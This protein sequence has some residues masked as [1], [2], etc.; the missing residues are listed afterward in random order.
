VD[1]KQEGPQAEDIP[2]DILFEDASILVLNKPA[3]LIVHP[4][5]GNEDGTLVNALIH[6]DP[7]IAEVG[8]EE[9]AGIVHRLDKGTSGVM[10]IAKTEE[11]RLNLM[12][13][14]EERTVYK[15]Y[16]ALVHGV[17]PMQEGTFDDPIGRHPVNRKKMAVV[18]NGR[19]AHTDY[20]ILKLHR[21]LFCEVQIVLH[22]GRTHQIRVHL[23]HAGHPIVGD[24]TYGGKRD[25]RKT[26]P[27]QVREALQNF[28]RPALHA[29]VL[30]IKHP[31]TGDE[32]I[33]DAPLAVELKTLL[34]HLT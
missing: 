27:K 30:K 26:L 8:F 7:K 5:A 15:E 10:V 21:G 32:M 12:K 28:E 16:W 4:G 2:L 25:T 34:K 31:D 9:R 14:F 6:H 23:S 24:K 11:S 22:T 19:P 3:G 18:P 20:I 33:F 17:L 1:S 13:Q 29:R